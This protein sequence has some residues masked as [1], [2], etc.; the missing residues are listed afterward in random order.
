MELVRA[1]YRVWDDGDLDARLAMCDPEVEL[2]TSGSFPDL[3]PVYR[4]HAGMRTFWDSLRAPWESFRL[5]PERIVVGEGC[6]VVA[7][8]FR[9]RGMGSGVTTD[10]EQGHALRFNDRRVTRVSTHRSFEEA[11]EAAGMSEASWP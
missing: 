8:R 11:L 4:G 1:A 5:R 10:L 2:L 9:V 6:A 3:A 7:V